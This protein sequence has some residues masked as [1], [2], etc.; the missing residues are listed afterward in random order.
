MR[1][2]IVLVFVLFVAAISIPCLSFSKDNLQTPQQLYDEGRYS[3]AF[4]IWAMRANG[5][6]V[7]A[8]IKISGMY[9]RGEGVKKNPEMAV[10]WVKKAAVRG[11]MV[12]QH[13]LARSYERGIGTGKDLCLAFK[14]Y[15]ESAA[16]GYA[17]SIFRLGIFYS[18]GF[19]ARQD[20]EKSDELILEAANRGSIGAQVTIAY[21]YETKDSRTI[22]D[23]DTAIFW[24]QKAAEQGYE[25][26]EERLVELK[27]AKK[28][29]VKGQGSIKGVGV[30]KRGRP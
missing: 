4:E 25:W 26:A 10:F 2:D 27:N 12:A 22:E 23:I 5:G 6:D 1:K 3:E 21:A 11:D 15:K 30:N 29:S 17:D 28:G 19:C 16:Q 7:N 8:Q 24:Y 20:L 13:Y 9:A 14:W 18:N